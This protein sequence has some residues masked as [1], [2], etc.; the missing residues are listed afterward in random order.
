VIQ[1]K[2]AGGLLAIGVVLWL[3]TWLINR[4]TNQDP[5]PPRF[6]DLKQMDIDPTDDPR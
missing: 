1:Y 6:A 3:L 2:I 5:E 4:F